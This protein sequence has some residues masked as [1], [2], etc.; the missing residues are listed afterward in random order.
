METLSPYEKQ[1]QGR[2]AIAYS[3]TKNQFKVLNKN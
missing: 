3:F 1:F 2:L